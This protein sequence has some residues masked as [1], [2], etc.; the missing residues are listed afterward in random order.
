MN[1]EIGS[2]RDA[3]FLAE[4]E[5]A[6]K[7]VPNKLDFTNSLFTQYYKKFSEEWATN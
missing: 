2:R 3:G 6:Y 5:N 7:F 4:E 1:H